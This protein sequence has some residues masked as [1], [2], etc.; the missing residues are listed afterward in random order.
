LVFSHSA[1]Q[2]G[3]PSKAVDGSILPV[4]RKFRPGCRSG[5]DEPNLWTCLCS[6]ATRG[7]L[8]GS[9]GVKL[10]EGLTDSTLS[11]SAT[12]AARIWSTLLVSA[13]ASF[14]HHV[15]RSSRKSVILSRPRCHSLTCRIRTNLVGATN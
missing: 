13:T 11:S 2:D 14:R 10:G 3:V 8:A 1:L 9:L 4:T 6:W 15:A 7:A 5:K 12:I